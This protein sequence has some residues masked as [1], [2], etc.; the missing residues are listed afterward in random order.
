MPKKGVK[1]TVSHKKPEHHIVHHV[2]EEPK[3]DRVLIENFVS[4]Q[5]VLTNLAVKLDGVSSQMSKLLDLFEISAKALAEKD[6]HIGADNRDVV[7]KLDKL[8]DQNKILARGISLMHERIPR[9]QYYPSVQQ[10]NP[11]QMQK[12][13]M[14]QASPYIREMPSPKPIESMPRTGQR[15]SFSQE[16]QE[17]EITPQRFES[18]ME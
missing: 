17:D 11:P 15:M 2:S 4:L 9:E 13:Q 5:R 12:Q 14:P 10:Q 18:P 3:V 8:L 7:D 16:I 1:K 6:F